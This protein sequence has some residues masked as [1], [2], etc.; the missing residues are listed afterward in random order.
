MKIKTGFASVLLIG[1]FTATTALADVSQDDEG[2]ELRMD[3][4]VAQAETTPE[5]EQATQ[6]GPA[7]DPLD[8][9]PARMRAAQ[10]GGDQEVS[11]GTAFNPA[12][13]VILDAVYYNEFS[14]HVEDPP[15]FDGAHDH[16]HGGH[17][18]GLEPGFQI[19]E[20][21]MAFSGTVDPYFDMF[22]M[23]AFFESGVELEEAY[24]TSR[25][26]PAGLQLKAGRFLSDVGYINKQHIHDWDFVDAPW[27]IENLFG[28]EGLRENGIQLTW[29]PATRSYMRFGL[30]LLNGESEGVAN[31]VGDGRHEMVTVLPAHVNDPDLDPGDP[32]ADAPDRNRWRADKNLH[33][34]SSPRLMTAFA[35]WA[36]DIGYDHALQLGVFG[37]VANTYQREE[38]HSS[39]R[40]ETWDGDSQF[41]G[42]DAVYKYTGQGIHGHRNFQLQAEYIRREL[43][44]EYQSRQFTDFGTLEPTTRA[45]G[46]DVV[47]QNW[48]Q[49]GFYMQGIYGF[50]P[51]WNVGLRFDALGLTNDAYAD[52]SDGRGLATEYETSYRYALQ[53]TYAPTEFSR[54]RAQL[55]YNDYGHEHGHSGH[56][57]DGA[58]E[59]MLQYNISLGVHGAHAF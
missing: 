29:M 27:A 7:R 50:A 16:G 56:D 4:V 1:S 42:F 58:W 46:G 34:T 17:G 35:K 18:H 53:T 25:A 11:S 32:G 33:E 31:Y 21:E 55:N 51:R 8:P 22:V 37:G 26:L 10:L 30:E 12:I 20:A 45:P 38:T 54:F 28:E 47:D 49:D 40:L 9:Q 3:D 43:D 39:G 15:G 48:V 41:Y 52:S 44:L 59:F 24:V 6:A 19:R 14:G 23:A 13:S 2:L 36:P 5:A 57:H